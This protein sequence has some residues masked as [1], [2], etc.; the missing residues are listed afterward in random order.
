MQL[1]VIKLSTKK[2]L[3]IALK[4]L[5]ALEHAAEM[6]LYFQSFLEEL[7]LPQT[8]ESVILES[9]VIL[10]RVRTYLCMLSPVLSP[11]RFETIMD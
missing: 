1:T 9:C 8:N 7:K 2:P 3:L 4:K 5:S 10:C 11:T 6:V